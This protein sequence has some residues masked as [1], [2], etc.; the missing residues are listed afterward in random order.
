[1][2]KTKHLQDQDRDSRHQDQDQD[3]DFRPQDQD[4]DRPVT[5][6]GV[7]ASGRPPSVSKRSAF[8]GEK[9]SSSKIKIVSSHSAFT[10][11]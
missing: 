11:K 7:G 1:M 6:G 9:Y 2:T 5:R 4:Q 3:R 8:S 10:A